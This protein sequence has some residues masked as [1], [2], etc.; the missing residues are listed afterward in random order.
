MVFQLPRYVRQIIAHSFSSFFSDISQSESSLRGVRQSGSDAVRFAAWAMVIGC[1]SLAAAERAVFGA[2][3]IVFILADD[4]GIG[5]LGALGQSARAAAGLPAIK[6]PNLDALAARS[7]SFSRMYTNPTC[8]PSRASLLTGLEH[9]HV[10]QE[11]VG[12]TLGLRPGDADKTWAQTLQEGGYRTA[13]Y[14]KWHVGFADAA[15]TPNATYK[16]DESP[17]Q[18]GFEKVAGTLVGGFRPTRLWVEDG[19][20][21]M[22]TVPNQY[23]PGWPGPGLSFKFADDAVTDYAVQFVR[24][25][26]QTGEQFAAYVALNA[27]HEP[28]N[29][30]PMGQ[31][32]SE[33][34]PAVQRQYAAMVTNVDQNVGRI[35][36]TLED[37]NNDGNTSDSIMNNTVVM[38][39]SDNGVLWP[40]HANGFDPEFFNS[41]GPF[42]G[43][44][45]NTLEGGVRTPF[46][47]R[48]DGVTQPGSVNSDFVGSLADVYPTI[49]ELA[50]QDVPFGLDGRSMASAIAGQ[51]RLATQK[52]IT[53][54][55]RDLHSGLN[56]ASW[57]V[58]IGDWK[59]IQ[60]MSNKA[61]ELYN[62][63]A[64][65]G[66]ATNLAS[67]RADIRSA[68][69]QVG[70]LEG[71]MEET[72]FS[73]G[74]STAPIN[75]Y[76]AQY[77]DW[78][79]NEASANFSLAANWSGGTQ[80][81][82]ANGPETKYWNT[83]PASN[84]MAKLANS[85]A[86]AKQAAISQNAV[87]LAMQIEGRGAPMTVDVAAGINIDAYNGVR[88]ETGGTLRLA[89]GRVKT[90]GE[91]EVRRF[92]RFAGNGV[93]EGYQNVLA[94]IPEFAGTKFL[95][96]HVKN[97]GEIDLFDADFAGSLQ[98]NGSFEQF[99][100]GRLHVD[101]VS[102]NQVD[103][104]SVSGEAW[105]NGDV[106]VD[107]ADDFTPTLGSRFTF[108]TAGSLT[109]NGLRLTGADAGLFAPIVTSTNISLVYT[110]GELFADFDFNGIVNSADLTVL[111]QNYGTASFAGDANRDG[112]VD[113]YDYLIWQRTFGSVLTPQPLI[114]APEPSACVLA[115]LATGLLAL[116]R[117]PSA[118]VLMR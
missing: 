77:K 38:F 42:R 102:G 23:I 28:F 60:R 75:T 5:D 29:W 48:W 92:G 45:S 7:L 22:R 74:V 11:N 57:T 95:Q 59:L 9:Q 68:L 70:A 1:M 15:S 103:A 8:A 18:Q 41:N 4:L 83:G 37:P 104:I 72:Y 36:A 73:T 58:Q 67:A 109:L 14:G 6:T 105:F 112:I 78:N 17:T 115:L 20:G 87:V 24:D 118:R 40:G 97:S 25:K 64:D 117:T 13:M 96:A 113:G 3:N 116:G 61:Y 66:E 27:P 32:E 99:A 93:V 98:V 53:I 35:L 12:E 65:P 63:T 34:W 19:N 16:Y 108:L 50:G 114:P 49:A 106:D 55:S 30:L 76:L 56:Q 91:F 52:P 84:W 80:F 107:L 100:T 2:P 47:V 26:S 79:S 90:I 81:T 62:I 54:T 31:Y 86:V 110:A 39:A 82:Q 44:K 46:F 10:I 101:V 69:V 85:S 43:E 94:G 33:T 111:G 71:A 88:I 51:G 89:G 21:G